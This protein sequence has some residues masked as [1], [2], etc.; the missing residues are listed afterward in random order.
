MLPM[1]PMRLLAIAVFT[2]LAVGACSEVTGP[3]RPIEG[4][5]LFDQYCAR[6]HGVD[7]RGVPEQPQARD[8][9]DIRIVDNLSDD[10]IEGTIRMG[11]PPAMPA[12]ADQFTEATLKVLVAYVRSLS[13]S[14]G[15]HARPR[16]AAGGQ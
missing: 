5:K 1:T 9:S 3:E 8:L 4:K 2:T 15:S 13:G 16:E 11:R 10:S 7:G 6:C 12:F 14:K